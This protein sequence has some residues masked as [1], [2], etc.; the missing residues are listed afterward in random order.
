MLT[1]CPRESFSRSFDPGFFSLASRFDWRL[2]F[3]FPVYVIRFASPTAAVDP[4]RLYSNT[5]VIGQLLHQ[6]GGLVRRPRVCPSV[7]PTRLPRASSTHRPAGHPDPA[8]SHHAAALHRRHSCDGLP[9]DLRRP[10]P[11]CSDWNSC[12]IP[13][14]RPRAMRWPIIA[15]LPPAAAGFISD[16][17]ATTPPPSGVPRNRLIRL[18]H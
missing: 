6:P 10:S 8:A 14:R 5:G 11:P 1:G 17:A 7:A 16:S 2:F 3:G 13:T 9:V 18:I 12:I 15:A 4:V